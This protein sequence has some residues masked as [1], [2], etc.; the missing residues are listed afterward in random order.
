[1]NTPGDL[2][3]ANATVA[4]GTLASRITGFL[5][6]ALVVWLVDTSLA[7][8]FNTANNIP[9]VLYE[10]V[11]GGV[12]SASIIPLFTEFTDTRDDESISAVFSTA[13]VA[14]AGVTALATAASWLIIRLYTLWPPKGVDAVDIDKFRGVA[15]LFA[16]LLLPQIFF[17]GLTFLASAVL[18]ARRRFLAA[19]WAPVVNNIIVILVL[20][21]LGGKVKDLRTLEAAHRTSSVVYTVG[22]ASTVGIVAMALI[23]VP[24]MRSSGA[25]VRFRPNRQHPAVRRVLAMS[26][27]TIG[28]TVANQVSLYVMTVL[29]RPGSADVTVMQV[30]YL[31]IMLPY[32]LFAASINTTFGPE[33][34][35]ARTRH[36][37]RAFVNQFTLGF[38][39]LAALLLPISAGMVA[40]ARPL[41]AVLIEHGDFFKGRSPN[42]L[43]GTVAAFAFGLFAIGGFLFTMRGFFAHN[44]TRTPFALN[45]VENGLAI[46]L[47]IVLVRPLGVAG[48]AWATSFAYIVALGLALASLSNKMGGIGVRHLGGSFIRLA[49]AATVAGEVAWL[50][51]RLVGADTGSGAWVRLLVGSL[52][53]GAAYLAALAFQQAPELSA[54][55]RVGRK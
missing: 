8:A 28:Y 37:R 54:V 38:R 23:L 14:L 31:L 4:I 11:L 16:Y 13:L 6:I 39:S 9:N 2:L 35:R 5:R 51:S 49:V 30:G 10:L 22:I 44:D 20:G 7:D 33:L 34:A 42:A 48:L 47:A 41:V 15:T 25:R 21:S 18:N 17:Y 1:V 36:D 24:A 27:W 50:T 12:L 53:G 3:R 43:A 52:L 32:G 40:L 29:A 46:I 55:R 26:T 45:V 19:A